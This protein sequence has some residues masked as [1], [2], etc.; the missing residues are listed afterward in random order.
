MPRELDGANSQA[1]SLV[2]Q[3]MLDKEVPVTLRQAV[4]A[5]S[6]RTKKDAPNKIDTT[7]RG[8]AKDGR[9]QVRILEETALQVVEAFLFVE[10]SEKRKAIMP[11]VSADGMRERGGIGFGRLTLKIAPAVKT[12]VAAASLTTGMP[13]SLVKQDNPPTAPYTFMGELKPENKNDRDRHELT[14]LTLGLSPPSSQTMSHEIAFAVVFML[15]HG[16]VCGAGATPKSDNWIAE[17]D[18]EPI[19]A[20]RNDSTPP[21]DKTDVDVAICVAVG[22][23]DW[24][25]VKLVQKVPPEKHKLTTVVWAWMRKG[26]SE[27]ENAIPDA[28]AEKLAQAGML[29]V[30]DAWVA[31]DS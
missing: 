8:G 15:M 20:A 31:D 17:M 9:V 6:E 21:H 11:V 7:L 25:S 13:V 27:H 26:K 19:F 30:V 4:V 10:G 3:D 18:A 22:K 28:D 12:G 24:G 16:I 29:T 2:R 1:G 23:M 5:A 14:L